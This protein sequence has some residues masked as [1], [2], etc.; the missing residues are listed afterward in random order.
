MQDLAGIEWA[1]GLACLTL[2]D[3]R[4]SDLAPLAGLTALESLTLNHNQVADVSPLEALTSL[5][6]LNLQSNRLSDIRP[7]AALS[8]IGSLVLFDNQIG[9]LAPLAGLSDLHHLE[10]SSNDLTD[11]S[12]LGGLTHLSNL[13]LNDN[14]VVD[15][16]PLGSLPALVVLEV[17]GNSVQDI[18]VLRSLDSLLWLDL[19]RNPLNGEAIDVHIPALEAAGVDVLARSHDSHGD[20]WTAATAMALG[21]TVAAEID[22]Y[23][24]RDSFRVVLNEAG[25]LDV[26]TAAVFP[27]LGGG[28]WSR[29]PPNLSGRLLDAAGLEVQRDNVDGGRVN[30]LLRKRLAAGT[31]YVE[32]GVGRWHIG[33]EYGL[34]AQ[35]G[36]VDVDFRDPA[37]R[38]TMRAR[39]RKEG[40]AIV[41]SSEMAAITELTARRR[42][43]SG[44][45]GLEFATGLTEL[46]LDENALVDL[47]PLAR[48]ARLRALSLKGNRIEDVSPLAGLD[49]LVSLDL[50]GNEIVDISP[51]IAMAGLQALNAAH[52]PL[53]RESVEVHLP[54]LI[55]QGV[56]VHEPDDRHADTPERA[57]AISLGQE[58]SGSIA[59]VYDE[60][61]F[62]LELRE[63][64]RVGFIGS[65]HFLMR[66][67]DA[68]G[69]ELERLRKTSDGYETIVADLAPDTY[70]LEFGAGGFVPRGY[71]F[72]AI[73]V[74]DVEIPDANLREAV[75]R[76]LNVPADAALTTI[77][78]ATMTYLQANGSP[79]AELTGL[80]FAV[81]LRRLLLR[82]TG[83]SELSALTEL[84]DLRELDLGRN[85]IVDT[86]PLAGLRNLGNVHLDG[87]R[88][89]NV[90]PLG[91]WFP[92]FGFLQLDLGGNGITDIS[93]LAPME[94]GLLELRSNPLNDESIDLLILA[95]TAK[96]V[97]VVFLRDHADVVERA[98]PI[99]VD[100]NAHGEIHAYYD[101]DWFRVNITRTWDILI[102]S[103]AAEARLFD[104]SGVELGLAVNESGDGRLFHL[105]RRLDPGLYFLEVTNDGKPVEYGINV[106]ELLG[107]AD[108]GLDAAI[109]HA[110]G[111]SGDAD[112]TRRS[113]AEITSLEADGA[114]IGDLS[115]IG[116]ASG[117]ERLYLPR[118]RVTDLSPLAA[119]RNLREAN[120]SDNGITNLAGLAGHPALESLWLSD[121]AISDLSPLAGLTRLRTLV[122]AEN[123]IE[124]LS[125]VTAL[126]ALRWLDVRRNPL[127]RTSVDKHVPG[128]RAKDVA[129]F[130]RDEHGDLRRTA[131]PIVIGDARRDVLEP[132]YDRD[133]FRLQVDRSTNAL[134]FTTGEED[135]VARLYDATGTHIARGITNFAGRNF[136]IH[137]ELEPGIYYL[138]VHS[139]GYSQV[140]PPVYSLMAW[141]N[142]V[143]DIPDYVLRR[144]LELGLGK[145]PEGDV[146]VSDLFNIG[147][148]AVTGGLLRNLTGLEFAA[149]LE[150][151]VLNDNAVADITPLVDLPSLAFL[152]LRENPLDGSAAGGHI[153]A[154]QERG[155]IV[156]LAD[157]HGDTRALGTPL[158]AGHAAEGLVYP[159]T[160][161]DYFSI[162][163]R[164]AGDL[165]LF[166]S[167]PSDTA[168]SLFD[169]S[170]Q[171]VAVDDDKGDGANFQIDVSL[172]AGT[173]A[174]EVSAKD[175]NS[176]EVFAYAPYFV[177]AR[178]S[179]PPPPPL[180]PHVSAELDGS[181]LVVVWNAWGAGGVTGYRVHVTQG[182]SGESRTCDAPRSRRRCVFENLTP[183]VSYDVTVE[184]L[185][186]DGAE[187]HTR[188]VS[189]FA[190]EPKTTWH[191]W[192]LE[193]L[194]RASEAARQARTEAVTDAP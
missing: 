176:Q 75:H 44:L 133:Y 56:V 164:R 38:R 172:P 34:H 149:F 89:E 91:G 168:G 174:L 171:E 45:A 10:I 129:V 166:T 11:I 15:L 144:A 190:S 7:L 115:G 57:T 169:E 139:Y 62:V 76:A 110:L 126:P 41:R 95:L 160:E 157:D 78:M 167:G 128:L 72:R 33:G 180:Q 90:A 63:A 86:G 97:N 113:V 143:L 121:N 112:L 83:V 147:S 16:T 21:D 29:P 127:S 74:V 1:I 194:H 119:L 155:V 120:L 80:E 73:E 182:D 50:E 85:A 108:S 58:V 106:D 17:G 154:L 141:E 18:E 184:A 170:G 102:T 84:T 131:T 146:W 87:N 28:Y 162:D 32:V 23:Y 98:T 36:A 117:L 125:P 13:K 186:S 136:L 9:E 71:R 138:D 105:R 163:L 158:S 130:L 177:H 101:R 159:I 111:K 37:L 51:L 49:N 173:Y 192:R 188:T 150:V 59:Q 52:N 43:I 64:K 66:L 65:G 135:T 134:L 165:Q 61:Y 161:K 67:L 31:Y 178:V 145:P 99:A 189:E 19:R 70:I 42:S 24:D 181:R 53:S 4:I 47:A 55:E 8:G 46:I 30:F 114:G 79:I 142:R 92:N 193:L 96:G 88:I 118:N 6:Y 20:L 26:A 25:E 103:V 124:D 14:E 54:R 107:F 100:G 94:Q 109:R 123:R 39:L 12:A 187:Q 183:G 137:R 191:G 3:N 22:P 156:V 93:P 40:D 2:G 140:P 68:D 185:T 27:A 60:D 5:R 175:A 48:L 104:E 82:N 81:H 35:V 151:L 153:R 179:F 152:D 77:D 116:S 132:Y 148:M 122:L 69:T